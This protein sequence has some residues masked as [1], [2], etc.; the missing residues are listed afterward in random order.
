M[1]GQIEVST[2]R[3]RVPHFFGGSSGLSLSPVGNNKS[4]ALCIA[5]S[6]CGER[7]EMIHSVEFLDRAGKVIRGT[8]VEAP[9]DPSAF[10]VVAND[11]PRAAYCVRIFPIYLAAGVAPERGE[12]RRRRRPQ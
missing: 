3:V 11:W 5:G 2:C 8:R 10:R 1:A 7:V 12:P 4:S 9:D 6:A